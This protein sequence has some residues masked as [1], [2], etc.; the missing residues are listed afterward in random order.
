MSLIVTSSG[1]TFATET[2][3]ESQ[4]FEESQASLV[5][6]LVGTDDVNDDIDN[7]GN[8][9]TVEGEG[10]NLVIPKQGSEQ[11]SLET[12]DGEHLTIG[13]PKDVDNTTAVVSE[14]GTIVYNEEDSVSIAVQ[15]IQEE[16][17]GLTIE[18]VRSMIVI[19]D[20]N[21]PQTY[22]FKYN[23]PQGYELMT[24]EEYYGEKNEEEGWV[25]IVDKNNA[26]TDAESDE[27]FFDIIAVIEPAWAKDANGNSVNTSYKVR[28]N[29]L[30]QTVYFN[31]DSSFPIVADPTTSTKPD[32]YK[33][34]TVYSDSFKL[35]NATLGL[36]GLGASA[37][38]A[39]LTKKAKEK[40]TTLITAKLGSKVIPVLNFVLLGLSGY[41]TYQGYKGYTYTKV[42]LSC[43]KW[44]I[45]KHQ[46]G[47]WVKGIGYKGKLS[48]KGSN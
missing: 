36:P 10:L 44:A 18:G 26:Y 32:N 2:T 16:Q 4:V 7:R 41:C 24:A 34:E 17:D 47:K 20:A 12:L 13:M 43:E 9:L 6:F 37:A 40:A 11:I 28:N 48:F 14:K 27:E 38:T 31:K 15:A 3:C 8:N 33:I 29:V 25:Y 19:N 1:A 46:G 23:L 45:Y 35:N 39:L 22:E 5:E 42:S 21:A 30:V